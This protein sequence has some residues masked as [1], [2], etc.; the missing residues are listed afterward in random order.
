MCLGVDI[1]VILAELVATRR[2]TRFL[3]ELGVMMAVGLFAI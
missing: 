2:L 1:V 3:I